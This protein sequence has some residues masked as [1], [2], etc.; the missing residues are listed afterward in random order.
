MSNSIRTTSERARLITGEL[1]TLG[2]SYEV[3]FVPQSD[4][5]ASRVVILSADGR[6]SLL[7]EIN[8]IMS[9]REARKAAYINT[10]TCDFAHV[11]HAMH[12]VQFR[13]EGL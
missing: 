11:G 5:G 4:P 2:V 13:P 8:R 7:E 12:C 10:C 6:R 3:S 1:L 9:E